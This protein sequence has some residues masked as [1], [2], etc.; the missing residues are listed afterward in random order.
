M[1][2][3]QGQTA[4]ARLRG[5]NREETIALVK[6]HICAA[7]GLLRP[8]G[9]DFERVAWL[10]EDSTMYLDEAVFAAEQQTPGKPIDAIDGEES[11]EVVELS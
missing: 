4:S 3:R 11:Q 7:A 1:S 2:D 8:L 6:E 5:K 9:E 10:I